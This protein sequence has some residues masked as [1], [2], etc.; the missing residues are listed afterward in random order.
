[1]AAIAGDRLGTVALENLCSFRRD[2]IQRLLEAN[3][4]ERAVRLSLQWPQDAP[5]RVMRLRRL[6]AL[7]AGVAQ[8]LFV[9]VIAAHRDEPVVLDA[10]HHAAMRHAQPAERFFLAQRHR[11]SPP[12][13][14]YER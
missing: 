9:V 6:Q 4:D 14:V 2:F 8:R 1:R 5:R 13:S 3:L 10:E 11:M 12:L 7:E